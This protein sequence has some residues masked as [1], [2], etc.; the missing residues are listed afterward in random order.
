[1]DNANIPRYPIQAGSAAGQ[2]L[3]VIDGPLA[4]KT[5]LKRLQLHFSHAE[6]SP[7]TVAIAVRIF[8]TKPANAAEFNANGR[9]VFNA[10]SANTTV[11]IAP[12]TLAAWHDFLNVVTN[13]KERFLVVSITPSAGTLF[14]SASCE[15]W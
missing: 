13:E 11:C 1:M 4:E 5:L 12:N 2:I 10:A 8:E 6:A 3:L 15:V 9:A 7:I 14:A